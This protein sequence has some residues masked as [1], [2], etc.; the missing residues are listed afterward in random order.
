MVEI[1]VKV[2]AAEQEGGQ[3]SLLDS[4]EGRESA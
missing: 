4:G 1:E 3:R 2:D